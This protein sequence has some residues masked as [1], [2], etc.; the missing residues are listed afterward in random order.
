MPFNN[1][2]NLKFKSPPT[3]AFFTAKSINVAEISGNKKLK[4]NGAKS[5]VLR[6]DWWI[7]IHFLGLCFLRSVDTGSKSHI[8]RCDWWISIHFVIF[9]G[10]CF[11]QSI[12]CQRTN[13]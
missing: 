11:S 2:Q 3:V 4:F 10:F 8:L 12:D 9:V 6:Y 1:M 13:I 5:H 7:L